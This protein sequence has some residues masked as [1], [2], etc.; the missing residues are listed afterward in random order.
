MAERQIMTSLKGW[1]RARQPR[2][3]LLLIGVITLIFGLLLQ[4]SWQQADDYRWR[5]QQQLTQERQAVQSLPMWEAALQSRGM[6]Q[7]QHNEPPSVDAL[8]TLAQ[9]Q[10]LMLQVVTHQK[11]W[12]L[13]QATT[14]SFPALLQ[15][16]TEIKNRWGIEA[17]QMHMQRDKQHVRL[18]QLELTYVQ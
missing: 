9:Q 18:T 5:S 8:N 11:G 10:G 13:Q 6:A 3:R 14:L 15:W 16:L 7:T 4:L 17:S 12:Q 2:E 1:W